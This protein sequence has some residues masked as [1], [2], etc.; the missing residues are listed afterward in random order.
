MESNR[1]LRPLLMFGRRI[2]PQARFLW[3]RLTPGGGLGLEFT[4]VMAVLAVAL[5]VLVGYAIEVGGNPGPTPGDVTAADFSADLRA[6][7]LT[8]IAKVV[9]DLGSTPFTLAVALV[10]GV[11]LGLRRR[12][13]E[14]GVLVCALVLSHVL[15]PVLKEAIDR[16]RPEGGLVGSSGDAYPSGHAAYSV[17]YTWLVLTVAVR[18]RPGLT[19]ATAMIVAGI[20]LT[21]AIGLSRVYLGVHY[22]SDVSGGWALGASAFGLCVVVAMTITHVRHNLARSD[23]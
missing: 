23:P 14:I 3:R 11:V 12:W 9:T 5:F 6:D 20:A 21:V 2:E 7:W 16:P 4:S 18:V 13:A 1:A 19:Y 15:V 17:I 22:F 8:D 10:A